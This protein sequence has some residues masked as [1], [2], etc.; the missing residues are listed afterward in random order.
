MKA[1]GRK[2]CRNQ[3]FRE[4]SCGGEQTSLATFTWGILANRESGQ[5]AKDSDFSPSSTTI[6]EG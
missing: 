1:V 4:E 5:E 2:W 6:A 3:S